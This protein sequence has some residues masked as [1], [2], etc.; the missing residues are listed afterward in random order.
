MGRVLVLAVVLVALAPS[1]GRAQ[2]AALISRNGEQQPADSHSYHPTLS[3]D[4]RF[5]AFES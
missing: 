5:V 1:P 4:G 2:V 3:A